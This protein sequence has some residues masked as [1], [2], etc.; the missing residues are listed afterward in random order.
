MTQLAE[1]D[2]LNAIVEEFRQSTG[3][4]SNLDRSV[5]R[6]VVEGD[7]DEVYLR[8]AADVCEREWGIK[9]IR[10]FAA[11]AGWN[12]NVKAEPTRS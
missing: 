8:A 5:T 2:I 9:P 1:A 3:V 12:Q 10:R 7:T 4:Q 11:A 6:V